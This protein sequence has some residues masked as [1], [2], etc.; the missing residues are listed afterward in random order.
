MYESRGGA[1]KEGVVKAVMRKEE[2]EWRT[3]M[4]EKKTLKL[5]RAVKQELRFEE[6]LWTRETGRRIWTWMRANVCPIGEVRRRVWKKEAT[7]IV[8]REE[9]ETRTHVLIRC[10]GYEGLRMEMEEG[11]ETE[12]E[13]KGWNDEWRAWRMMREERRVEMMLGG[14]GGWEREKALEVWK[15]VWSLLGK[16]W[17]LRRSHDLSRPPQRLL[18][19]GGANGNA[20]AT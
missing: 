13:R 4:K 9:E 6:E 19:L 12:F 16:L 15:R 8:C 18:S 14:R 1:T 20:E 17:D 3:R 7:C 11:M 2:E 10:R 5:Y